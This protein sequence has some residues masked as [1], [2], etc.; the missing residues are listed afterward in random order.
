[1]FTKL[2]PTLPRGVGPGI[3]D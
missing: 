3:G 1:M 2:H